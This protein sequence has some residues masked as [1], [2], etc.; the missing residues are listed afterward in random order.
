MISCQPSSLVYS[1]F[2]RLTLQEEMTVGTQELHLAHAL[3]FQRI[4]LRVE[5]FELCQG[6]VNARDAVV[7]ACPHVADVPVGRQY[8]LRD[9][10]LME[11]VAVARSVTA[12]VGIV[13]THVEVPH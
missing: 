6:G 11:H 1:V 3:V 9:F 2:E 13:G 7:E 5:L 10:Q 4:I 8:A 12:F